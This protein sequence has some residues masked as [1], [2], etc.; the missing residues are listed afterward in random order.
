[1]TKI[2]TAVDIESKGDADRD[3]PAD[4]AKSDHEEGE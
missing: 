2:Y 1:M 3:L 4:E